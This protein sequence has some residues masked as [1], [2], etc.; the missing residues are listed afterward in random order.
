MQNL[1]ND[2]SK[3]KKLPFGVARAIRLDPQVPCVRRTILRKN[4]Y[5]KFYLQQAFVIKLWMQN[6]A[7]EETRMFIPK[8][9]YFNG[10][11]IQY[12]NGKK[13]STVIN[14]EVYNDT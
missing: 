3:E 2:Y 13:Y 10:K 1:A 5:T 11:K 6:L 14:Y 8:C 7:N 9:E 12:F 4:N